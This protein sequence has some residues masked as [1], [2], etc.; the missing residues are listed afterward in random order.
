MSNN[1]LEIIIFSI[2]MCISSVGQENDNSPTGQV[3]RGSQGQQTLDLWA[4]KCGALFKS[5]LFKFTS[6]ICF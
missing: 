4:Q 2:E 5:E 6:G 1:H 3:L